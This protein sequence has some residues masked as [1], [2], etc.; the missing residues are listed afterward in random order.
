MVV[1]GCL[2]AQESQT[3]HFLFSVL[4]IIGSVVL[5]NGSWQVKI[6]APSAWAEK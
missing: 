6:N 5:F 4:M 1:L 2:L 3:M